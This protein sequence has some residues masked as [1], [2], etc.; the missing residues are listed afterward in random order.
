MIPN[1]LVQNRQRICAEC[2]QKTECKAKFLMLY[3]EMNCPLGKQL[4]KCDAIAARA[5]PQ[6]AERIS[7]CCDPIGNGWG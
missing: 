5:W 4:S 2:S 6:G 7:G 1:W 3:E